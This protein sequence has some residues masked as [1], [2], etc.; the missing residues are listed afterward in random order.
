MTD[1]LFGF[2][3]GGMLG[4]FIMWLGAILIWEN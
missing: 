2:C 3:L 1:F 4:A